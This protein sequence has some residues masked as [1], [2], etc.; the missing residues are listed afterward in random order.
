MIRN[1][2]LAAATAAA[3]TLAGTAFS[4]HEF[5]TEITRV[6]TVKK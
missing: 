5:Y 4:K 3:A 6:W 2:V 1:V